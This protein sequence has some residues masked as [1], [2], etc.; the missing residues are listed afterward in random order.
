MVQDHTR[1]GQGAK[2]FDGGDA[3]LRPL[4]CARRAGCVAMGRRGVGSRIVGVSVHGAGMR[5]NADLIGRA[6]WHLV[7]RPSHMR[8]LGAACLVIIRHCR[9]RSLVCVQST[10]RA[11]MRLLAPP[12]TSRFSD[13]LSAGWVSPRPDRSLPMTAVLTRAILAESTEE[14]FGAGTIGAFE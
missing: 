2:P 1:D 12:C 7:L 11:R 10:R 4:G 5:C 6:V 9:F 8:P 14:P 13:S 3:R